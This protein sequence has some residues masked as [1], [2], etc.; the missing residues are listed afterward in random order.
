[1]KR[2]L[3]CLAIIMG[4]N[5]VAQAG[6]FL[7][8]ATGILATRKP[9]KP[10]PAPSPA[11]NPSGICDN[12]NG[13]GKVGDGVTMLTCP[14]CKGTGKKT[15]EP[16]PPPPPPPPPVKQAPPPP[17]TCRVNA[18]GTR[19]CTPATAQP[20]FRFRRRGG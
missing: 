3:L 9:S 2:I 19:T 8:L 18:D 5:S 1:M 14:V 16:P 6:D 20:I 15:S 11:P 12:C 17:G 7:G 13:V 10:K 4:C